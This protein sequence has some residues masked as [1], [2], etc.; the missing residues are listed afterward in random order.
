MKAN[1]LLASLLSSMCAC[2]AGLLVN[3]DKGCI[4]EVLLADPAA[5]DTTPCRGFAAAVTARPKYLSISAASLAAI[6]L[7][8]DASLHRKY[9]V[10]HSIYLHSRGKARVW[11]E[12]KSW[13]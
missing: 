7:R 6:T 10:F 2:G 1:T 8:S 13:R 4:E 12:L 11:T 3:S 5:V 9:L